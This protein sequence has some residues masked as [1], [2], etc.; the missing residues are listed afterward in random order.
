MNEDE[1]IRI[2]EEMGKRLVGEVVDLILAGKIPS[3]WDGIELHWLF[4]QH[5]HDAGIRILQDT[6]RHTAYCNEVIVRNL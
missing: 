1:Q 3:S 5:A 6:L 4:T 2:V